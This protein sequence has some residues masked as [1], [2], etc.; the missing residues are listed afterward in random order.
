M[1]SVGGR[2]T[3]GR[4]PAAGAMPTVVGTPAAGELPAQ[5]RTA[6]RRSVLGST[7]ISPVRLPPGAR[8]TGPTR[9]G[10]ATGA[11]RAVPGAGIAPS[12]WGAAITPG[13]PA[14]GQWSS[15]VTR[16]TLN[17]G[18]PEVLRRTTLP[19]GAA[20]QDSV[21]RVGLIRA[22]LP[23]AMLPPA[24]MVGASLAPAGRSGAGAVIRSRRS[25]ESL[26]GNAVGTGPGRYAARRAAQPNPSHSIEPAT[27]SRPGRVMPAAWSSAGA[28]PATNSTYALPTS[29]LTTSGPIRR[30]A[31]HRPAERRSATR[32]GTGAGADANRT[33]GA[34]DTSAPLAFSSARAPAD[35]ATG[36]SL[37]TSGVTTSGV[38]RR[39]SALRIGQS[40][41]APAVATVRNNLGGR[42]APG[43]RVRRSL[44]NPMASRSE[45]TQGSATRFASSQSSIKQRSPAGTSPSTGNPPLT[46]PANPNPVG[47]PPT[48]AA[49]LVAPRSVAPRS[50]VPRFDAPRSEF[51][52]GPSP[53]DPQFAGSPLQLRHVI[54]PATTFRPATASLIRRSP[55]APPVGTP[56]G[57]ANPPVPPTCAAGALPGTLTPTNLAA[58]GAAATG[59]TALSRRFAAAAGPRPE[60]GPRRPVRQP[61]RTRRSGVSSMCR[62]RRNCSSAP[63]VGSPAPR[64]VPPPI[65]VTR[66]G[67]ATSRPTRRTSCR[68]NRRM[69]RTH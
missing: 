15:A 51:R 18:F 69:R 7:V 44:L 50:D 13:R 35:A 9:T 31:E 33:A 65:R 34:F 48:P 60:V 53:V 61:P 32:P 45:Q 24:S 3:T 11:L 2:P 68:V 26:P 25:R 8:P 1:P 20:A 37:L 29:G 23:P 46:G 17:P 42:P 6:L 56:R 5:G 66:T 64:T 41:S 55:A 22:A 63:A 4:A 16:R 14:S 30:S 10:A 12:T 40:L 39:S 21:Q 57:R 59:T 38:I 62:P 58:F 28:P 52:S 43:T 47:V 19:R 54:A 49:A 27:S 67:A 36:Y